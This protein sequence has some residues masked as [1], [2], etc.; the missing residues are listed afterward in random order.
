MNKETLF[1][2]LNFLKK[3][4]DDNLNKLHASVNVD[5]LKEKNPSLLWLRTKSVEIKDDYFRLW[6]VSTD[7]QFACQDVTHKQYDDIVEL[8]DLIQ[9]VDENDL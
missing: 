3:I 6:L 2:P 8:N 7:K 5:L 1:I 9:D 4:S